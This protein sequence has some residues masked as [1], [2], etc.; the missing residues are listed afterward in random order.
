MSSKQVFLKIIIILLIVVLLIIVL[1]AVLRGLSILGNKE[2]IV[3]LEEKQE[4]K[5]ENNKSSYYTAKKILN[6]YLI[7]YANNN[8]TAIESVN[9]QNDVQLKN[10]EN[11]SVLLI[12]EMY[13][14]QA[15]SAKNYFIKFKISTSD[16]MYYAIITTDAVNQTFL[17]SGI[18]EEEYSKLSEGYCDSKYMEYSNIEE[19]RYNKYEKVLID[20]ELTIQNYF[21]EYI[22]F[23]TYDQEKAYNM[24]DESY[25]ENR[26]GDLKTFKQYINKN[27]D[28][29]KSYNKKANKKYEDVNDMNE[30]LMY[31]ASNKNLELKSYQII[32]RN[33]YT[34][35]IAIDNFEN[36]YI[37][38]EKSPLDYSIILDTYSID[39]PEFIEKYESATVQEKVALN[40]EKV[41]EAINE[42]DY[43]Y[44]YN[45]LNETFKKNNFDTLEKFE[46]YMKKNFYEENEASYLRFNEIS[47]TYTYS[48]KIKDA[49]SKKYKTKNFVMKLGEG[50]EFEMSFGI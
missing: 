33:E 6:N 12:Y 19:S 39:L 14:F 48:V 4:I 47:G 16:K 3:E 46:K 40:L 35:Y 38:R 21:G 20:N 5:L 49:E 9:P 8:K 17:I 10:V 11:S 32:E 45:K 15:Q 1:I 43:K 34:Q 30:Y 13:S 23:C 44:V 37:I 22:Y 36:Y 26:F 41:I 42:Q 24:L 2:H 31:L 18:E 25:R 50:T 28:I 27:I 29:Y 7:Y